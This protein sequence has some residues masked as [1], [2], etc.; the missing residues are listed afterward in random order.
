M[1][2]D[3]LLFVVTVLGPGHVSVEVVSRHA[4]EAE[5][6]QA[7]PDAARKIVRGWTLAACEFRP[8]A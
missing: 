6:Y 1:A 7:M 8:S 5:C 2:F 3:W 4:T